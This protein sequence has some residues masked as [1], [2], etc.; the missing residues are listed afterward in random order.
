MLHDLT[1]RP[2]SCLF[3][4]FF[5]NFGL[6]A[7]ASNTGDFC[8]LTAVFQC[9]VGD[10]H[11]KC[12]SPSCDGLPA[13]TQRS[14]FISNIHSTLSYHI[15]EVAGLIPILMCWFV[16]FPPTSRR[17]SGQVDWRCSQVRMCLWSPRDG[18][19]SPPSSTCACWDM[20]I[21]E[22]P[23]VLSGVLRVLG[24]VGT[25]LAVSVRHDEAWRLV[26][27]VKHQHQQH[28]PHLVTGAQ[29][30]QLTWEVTFRDF[31][32]VENES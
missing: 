23:S 31:W 17:V 15:L 29:V 27:P 3:L 4:K 24:A 32:N 6:S 16:W 1:C 19:L 25:R 20:I 10:D 21:T 14:C 30:V 28:V 22:S 26:P 8:R 12:V 11:L 7:V 13:L 18:P 5:G 9:F 2:W